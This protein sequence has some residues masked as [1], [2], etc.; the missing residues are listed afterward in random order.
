MNYD[1]P[2]EKLDKITELAKIH[3]PKYVFGM[4]SKD[5]LIQE[6][7]LM[8]IDAYPRWDGKRPFANFICTHISNRLKTFKRDKFYRANGGSV[9]N[10]E[11][12]RALAESG[13]MVV[14]RS[15]DVDYA[16]DL[17]EQ[18]ILEIIDRDMPNH[19]RKTYLR[20]KDG[21]KVDPAKRREVFE[22]IHGVVKD[23][24]KE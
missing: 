15:Y 17:Y 18:E 11:A 2:E 19:L 23:V 6:A 14:A 8:G 5:D 3:A 22:Y 13:S 1:I 4:Y 20:I 16:N 21:V 24:E 12:K 9:K 7:I 10:Q